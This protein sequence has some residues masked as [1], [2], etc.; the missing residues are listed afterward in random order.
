MGFCRLKHHSTGEVRIHT[1]EGR[2]H[3]YP[4]KSFWELAANYKIKV[5][6]NSDAH[7]PKLITG[8]MKEGLEIAKEFGLKV[9]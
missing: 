7:Y 4:I 8:G 2:R 1:P 6:I 9:D 5:V 3:M